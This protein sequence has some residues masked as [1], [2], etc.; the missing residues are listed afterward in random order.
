MLSRFLEVYVGLQ[1]ILKFVPNFA[2]VGQ[3]VCAAFVG[4]FDVQGS[5]MQDGLRCDIV[6]KCVEVVVLKVFR[7]VPR[8]HASI[9]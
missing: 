4:V 1:H 8:R 3:V 2:Q 5:L 7:V 6:L 9:G